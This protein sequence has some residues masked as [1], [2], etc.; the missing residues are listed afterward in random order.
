MNEVEIKLA[1]SPENANQI[2]SRLISLFGSA[3]DTKPLANSYFDTPEQILRQHKWSLRIREADDYIEQTIKGKGEVKAGLH[4]RIEKNWPL[5]TPALDKTKLTEVL[6]IKDLPLCGLREVFRTKFAR[7]IWNLVVGE[8]RIELVLDRGAIESQA[9]SQVIAE[10]ECEL[11][12]G[13]EE[14]LV[15]LAEKLVETMPCWLFSE[16]KAYRGYLLSDRGSAFNALNAPEEISDLLAWVDY[17][18]TWINGLLTAEASGGEVADQYER[19]LAQLAVLLKKESDY[20][21]RLQEMLVAAQAEFRG[22]KG[23]L[24]PD[25][26]SRY[27]VDSTWL[28]KLGVA[29]MKAG[30][31]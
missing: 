6:E 14:Q 30:F 3:V 29:C 15:T 20:S 24:Q 5:T 12:Q 1:F 22:Q 26:F 10:I 2:E 16:S 19:L 31:D 4:S 21:H 28:G 18:G 13:T 9:G 27:L 7:Q 23:C 17:S 8:S 25:Q 11:K